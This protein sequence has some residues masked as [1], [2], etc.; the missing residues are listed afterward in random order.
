MTTE[1]RLVSQDLRLESHRIDQATRDEQEQ[2]LLRPPADF[3]LGALGAWMALG[4]A[5]SLI[6]LLLGRQLWLWLS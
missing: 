4:L 1:K 5:T 3:D 6:V 2:L